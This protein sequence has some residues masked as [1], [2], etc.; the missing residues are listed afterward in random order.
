MR[1]PPTS[2]RWSAAA[3]TT[4]STDRVCRLVA[5]RRLPCRWISSGQHVVRSLGLLSGRR[6]RRYIAVRNRRAR[7]SPCLGKMRRKYEHECE[8]ASGF[9]TFSLPYPWKHA[10]HGLGT[11]SATKLSGYQLRITVTVRPRGATQLLIRANA[12]YM[13]R[14]VEDAKP[15]QDF[16]TVLEKSMFLT[17]HQVD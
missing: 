2:A 15:Y 10:N 1:G 14:A 8:R 16:F 3:S 9:P 5:G 12:Q 17:A 13:D 6:Q 4:C 7:W 11:V